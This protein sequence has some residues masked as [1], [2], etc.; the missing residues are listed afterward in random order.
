MSFETGFSSAQGKLMQILDELF[1]KDTSGNSDW[2]EE[3]VEKFSNFYKEHTDFRHLY[4]DFFSWIAEKTSDAPDVMDAFILKL[5]EIYKKIV[6]ERKDSAEAKSLF[7][8]YDHLNIEFAR[9]NQQQISSRNL[10]SVEEKVNIINNSFSEVENKVIEVEGK[11]NKAASRVDSLKLDIVAVI[12]LFSGIIITFFGGLNYISS[13]FS[14]LVAAE[15][16]KLVLVCSVIGFIVF[17]IIFSMFYVITRVL[18]RNIYVFCRKGNMRDHC[19]S[20][21]RRCFAF[22]MFRRRMPYVFWADCVILAIAVISGIIVY[23]DTHSFFDAYML[24]L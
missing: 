2:I 19:S 21:Q 1:Q 8:L 5:A 7:K 6:E 11:L 24:I 14:N 10:S 18:D 15:I 23:T 22:S 16:W 17:N 13:A 12:S 3:Y 4:S 9:F 20:C